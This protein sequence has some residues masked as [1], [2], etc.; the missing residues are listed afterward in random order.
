MLKIWVKRGC[1]VL[2]VLLA[3]GLFLWGGVVPESCVLCDQGQ[4]YHAP[5][6]V[7]LSTGEFGPITVYDTNNINPQ[8]L[9]DHQSKDTASFVYCADLT[10]FRDTSS[11]RCLL[12]VPKSGEG[13]DLSLFCRSCRWQIL[14]CGAKGYVIVDLYTPADPK[15]YA[16]RDGMDI[17][18][19]CYRIEATCDGTDK[20][21]VAVTGLL[22]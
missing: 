16:I 20:Y 12:P 4:A 14:L 19:R 13:I 18:V 11:H 10:G 22:E 21:D 9:S 2:A 15:F 7:K 5:C 8:L 3:V 6:I 17:Q 1:L